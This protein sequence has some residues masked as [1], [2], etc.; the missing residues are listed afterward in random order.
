MLELLENIEVTHL[1]EGFRKSAN[2][3]NGLF[4]S[5]AELLKL[6][7]DLVL[8]ITTDSI[9]EEIESGLYSDP[10]QIGWMVVIANLSDLAAVGALPEGIL[11]TLAIP[12][13]LKGDFKHQIM[14]G[15]Q[16]ACQVYD[17]AV[18]GGDTNSSSQLALGAT[19]LGLIKDG[20]IMMRSGASSSDILYSTGKFGQGAAYA[21]EKLLLGRQQSEFYPKARLKESQTVRQF[22][23]ACIDTSDGF[24]PAIC[25]L[26]RQNQIGFQIQ[27]ELIDL[28]NIESQQTAHAIDQ[29]SWIP[30]AGPHGEFELLFTIPE[31]QNNDFI[32]TSNIAGW[33]PTRIGRATEERH[34]GVLLDGR[35]HLIDPFRV[36]NLY[37]NC[38]GDIPKYLIELQ[39]IS[40]EWNL[41]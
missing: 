6:T 16:K 17:V 41:L 28:V 24:F 31:D 35:N 39:K 25:N 13:T 1:V 14:Q 32:E 38:K 37:T 36:A 2:Q 30:L 26:M 11:I 18:L 5:D 34:L 19:A 33:Q 29:E 40:R 4:E 15:I 20:Q 9:N 27:E 7:S 21:I 10:D 22:A 3:L 12:E 8:A 23:S